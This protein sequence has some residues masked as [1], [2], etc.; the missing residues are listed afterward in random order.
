MSITSKIFWD[1]TKTG[2]VRRLEMESSKKKRK[3][4]RMETCVQKEV[5][6]Q[7]VQNMEELMVRELEEVD[8]DEHAEKRS[9]MEVN[10]Q[11]EMR[12]KMEV[13]LCKQ[14]II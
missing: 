6:G 8:K 4:E 13:D 10:V 1:I 2:L 11:Q 3:R 14:A 12:E 5:V 7:A 9:K